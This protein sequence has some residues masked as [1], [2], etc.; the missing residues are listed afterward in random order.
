MSGFEGKVAVVTGSSGI[1]LGAAL[2]FARHGATVYVC[3]IDPALNETARAEG[4]GFAFSV[5]PVDVADADQVRDWIDGIAAEAGGI[6]ILVNAAAIQTYGDT[7][8]T[9]V[10]HWNRSI[11]IN[12]T[13]CYLT[14]HF[15]Y[16]HMKK[17]G[18]GSIVHVSS[19]QGHSNQF[20][21]LAYATTKGGI[22]AF[23]RA[24]AVDAARDGIRVNSISPGSIRTPLLEFAA[25]EIVGE[26][27]DIEETIAG[28]G[29]AH[30]IGRVGTVEETSELIGFLCSDKA[31]FCTGADY[32][33]D[34]ALTAHIGV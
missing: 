22:H 15:A 2:H 29:K 5:A 8:S 4:Q 9:D 30:P 33:I 7:E 6:D 19:V 24:Q 27:N 16:P 31:G 1:G 32:R 17:R 26:G 21:V 10:A 34:G 14:S 23:T 20:G 12:L 11:A 13:S 28:F 3:G 25:R 18:G